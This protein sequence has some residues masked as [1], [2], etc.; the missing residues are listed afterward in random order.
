M[1]NSNKYLDLKQLVAD[2]GDYMGIKKDNIVTSD[3]LETEELN[4][5]NDGFQNNN[6]IDTDWSDG[7]EPKVFNKEVVLNILDILRKFGFKDAVFDKKRGF[8]WN[9]YPAATYVSLQ[10][11]D[12]YNKNKSFYMNLL[13]RFIIDEPMLKDIDTLKEKFDA[14]EKE[15]DFCKTVL[16]EISKVYPIVY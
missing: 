9:Y 12:K 10:F 3:E 8:I 1:Q 7:V 13:N 2:I 6:I 4:K 15:I 5:N 14:F 11:D 16:F